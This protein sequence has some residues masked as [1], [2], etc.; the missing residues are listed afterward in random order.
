MRTLIIM[1]GLAAAGT[2][3]KQLLKSSV[4]ASIGISTF[5][6]LAA[7]AKANGQK[8]AQRR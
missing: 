7:V 6:L 2:P 4:Y 5:T 3:R 1:P 8:K